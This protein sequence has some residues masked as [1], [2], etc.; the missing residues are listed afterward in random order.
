[1]HC[2][3][4]TPEV[5]VVRGLTNEAGRDDADGCGSVGRSMTA[6]EPEQAVVTASEVNAYF[7]CPYAWWYADRRVEPE[8][9]A[10]LQRGID[11]HEAVADGAGAAAKWSWALLVVAGLLVAAAIVL[12]VLGV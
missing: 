6:Q 2:P 11:Y 9:M 7:Y 1:M 3:T 10:L 5:N 8:R 12:H 4:A